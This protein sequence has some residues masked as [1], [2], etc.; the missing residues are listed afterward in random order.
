M[1][2]RMDTTVSRLESY[3]R[4]PMEYYLKYHRGVPAQV[5]DPEPA[6]TL[7]GNLLGDLV[8]GV[9]R[10]MMAGPDRDVADIVGGIAQ[11]REIPAALI[12]VDEIATWVGRALQYHRARQ[13][14]DTRMELPFVMRLGDNLLRGTIDFL[15]RDA[16]GWHVVDYKT[17]RLAARSELAAR[18]KSYALQMQAYAAAATQAGLQPVVDT[19]LL[20]LR[21]DDTITTAI[22]PKDAAAVRGQMAEIM[23]KIAGEN[24]KPGPQPPCKTC[25]YHHNGMCWED[26]LKKDRA[27]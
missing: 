20:F 21:S 18:A 13:W 12:S 8:H 4:C 17:D 2:I 22:I 23:K 1:N 24:W 3:S 11:E 14:T 15:G 10:E 16:A 7:P 6:T 9:I 19:T 27:T 25:P 26:R 5:V